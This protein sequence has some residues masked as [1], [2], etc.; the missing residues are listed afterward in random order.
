MSYTVFRTRL[1]RATLNR[2]CRFWSPNELR[3]SAQIGR[4]VGPK[5]VRQYSANIDLQYLTQFYRTKFEREKERILHAP[6]ESQ[7]SQL[8]T[9]IVE[10]HA[11]PD[12]V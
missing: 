11:R 7:D 3:N 10:P 8:P 1:P 4:Q 6:L 2:G 5:P 12:E 9:H